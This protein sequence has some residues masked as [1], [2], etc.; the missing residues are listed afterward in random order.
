VPWRQK[1][2]PIL[3]FFRA[4]PT[5]EV[6]TLSYT[7]YIYLAQVLVWALGAITRPL[8]NIL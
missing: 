5:R 4:D 3:T 8:F 6:Y 2:V 7:G 1:S